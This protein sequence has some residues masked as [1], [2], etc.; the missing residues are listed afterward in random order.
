MLQIIPLSGIGEIVPG[1]DLGA[2]LTGSLVQMGVSLKADDIIVVTQK[3]V[4]KSEGRFVDMAE[5]EP[6]SAALKLAALVRKD[7]RLVELV[8]RESSE[9]VRAVP[10]VLITRHRLGLV[11]ANAGIDRSN[12]GGN[13]RERVLLLP[14]DPDASAQRIAEALEQDGVRPAVV[15]SDSFGRPWRLGVVS[16]GIGAAGLPSL[17]DRRGEMDRDG[18]ALEVTQVALADIV[19]TAASLCTGEGAEG[20]PAV[21]VRG[22]SMKDIARPAADLVRPVAEDLFR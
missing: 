17:I 8:L 6:G 22:Y 2:V 14:V 19:A 15:I 21:L 20:I 18:R 4:S 1:D 7:P 10:N 13:A 9:I 12:L 3:I 16:V 11:M 5:I